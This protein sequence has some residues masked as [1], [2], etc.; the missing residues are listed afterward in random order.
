MNDNDKVN[1]LLSKKADKYTI[2]RIQNEIFDARERNMTTHI[3]QAKYFTIMADG[4]ADLS[5][6]E[7]LVICFQYI[8]GTL[9]VHEE[10]MD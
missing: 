2:P 10:F 5:S 9:A 3:H 6:N 1:E 4:C 7:Q 8:E